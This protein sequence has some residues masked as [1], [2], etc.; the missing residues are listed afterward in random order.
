M[1]RRGG[2]RHVADATSVLVKFTRYGDA[3]LDGQVNLNDFNRLAGN[4][5][6]AT[7]RTWSQGD[8]TYDGAVNLN[9]FNRL[10]ANFGLFAAGP[11]VAPDDWAMLASRIP[12][13]ASPALIGMAAS[14]AMLRRR[15]RPNHEQVNPS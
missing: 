12:E 5:G 10:A 8:F 4:F 3:N 9:D 7:N 2:S 15:N 14:A 6:A 13:P 1:G 11:E